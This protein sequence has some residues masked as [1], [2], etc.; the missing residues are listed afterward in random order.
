MIDIYVINLIES[1]D[2]KKQIIQDFSIYKN[3]NLYFIEAI[4]HK[5][6]GIGCFLSHKK[7]VQY[8]KDNN[9]DYI[10]VAE[11]DC[12]PLEN[13][14]EKLIKILEDLQDE[15]WNIFLGGVKKCNRVLGKTKNNF[16]RIRN[17]LCTHLIIY[18]KNIY[19]N[20]LQCDET[21]N[22]IDRFWHNKYITLIKLPFI[23]HQHDG[24]SI[25]CPN[26]NNINHSDQF[27]ETENNLL[28]MLKITK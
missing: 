24:F 8:A 2:R 17:G 5:N 7:C 26:I 28:T 4:K 14:E 25:I 19:D 18:N 20:V 13:F 12:L 10:I 6:G 3:I 27:S 21:K 1:I 9:M 11:D 22:I 23:A 16:Y 15:E